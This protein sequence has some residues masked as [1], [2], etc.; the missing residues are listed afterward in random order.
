MVLLIAIGVA[1]SVFTAI[2]LV[3]VFATA[4]KSPTATRLA[5]LRDQAHF[6][7]VVAPSSGP[8]GVQGAFTMMTAPLAPFRNWLR[9]NDEELT[10]RLGVAGFRKPEDADTFLSCKL[11]GPV[12]GVLLATLA[13]LHD[14]LLYALFLGVLGFFAPDLFL[15][16]A[17]SKRKTKI[18][19]ALP[20]TLDLLCICMEAGLGIDQAVVRI[21][22]ELYAMQ[23][24]LS[25]ELFIISREQRAGKP[26]LE[27]WRSMA[28][29]VDLDIVR[30]FVAML[31]QTE[32]LGT[33]IARALSQFADGLRTR[34]LM[35]AEEHAAK[36]TIKLIFPLTLFIFP[37]IFIVLLGPG[38]ITIMQTFEDLG[39]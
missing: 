30:Q 15:M 9:S 16:Y 8:G 14:L 5:E 13:P 18:G 25:E 2:A 21:A 3:L 39:K 32:R 7:E 36:T 37:A 10:Y 24:E 33:P 23:P 26:R 27:A 34:R 11:L 22:S 17:V 1:V 35:M 31:V 6:S 38:V 29:R 28:D 4:D 19:R 20:D 12:V